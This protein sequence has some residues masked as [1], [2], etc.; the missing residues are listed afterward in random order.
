MP[1]TTIDERFINIIDPLKFKQT[2][3]LWNDLKLNHPKNVGLVSSLIEQ[4]PFQ[5]KD[6]W[7]IFYFQSG[8]ER[9]KKIQKQGNMSSFQYNYGR[10]EREIK[11]IGWLLYNHIKERKIHHITPAEC[12]YMTKFRVIG[13]TW[14]GIKIREKKAIDWLQRKYPSFTFLKTDGEVDVQY[15]VDYEVYQ[16]K[17]LLFGLQ[18]KPPSYKA[19]K[20][21]LQK[22]KEI[23]RKKNDYYI[24]EKKVPICYLF[25]GGK[26]CFLTWYGKEKIKKQHLSF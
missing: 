5:T 3:A 7:K 12:V 10:T 1:H 8:E 9:L 19:N 20:P 16:D 17:R 22:A 18:I 23:N 24:E 15:A 25:Y 13:D 11:Q 14:N 26:E 21:Y 6:E 2:N 4:K